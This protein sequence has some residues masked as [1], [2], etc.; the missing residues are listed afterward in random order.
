M[1]YLLDTTAFSAVMRREDTIMSW[2]KTKKPGQVL[3]AP[4]VMA[5]IEYGLQRLDKASRR[6]QLLFVQKER[7]LAIFSVLDWIPLASKYFGKIKADLE[8]RGML[9]DDFDIAIGA[10]ALSHECHVLTANLKHF[11]RIQGLAAS[12]WW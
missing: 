9:I 12:S 1:K 11:Q 5:E 4:P 10:I 8:T 2:L 6:Y 3:T 7:L